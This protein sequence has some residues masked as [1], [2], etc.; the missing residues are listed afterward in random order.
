MSRHVNQELGNRGFVIAS[1]FLIVVTL[2]QPWTAVITVV[3]GFFVL[4]A[5]LK[6]DARGF[7]STIWR[8]LLI[9]AFLLGITCLW[10]WTTGPGSY[11]ENWLTVGIICT[12][13]GGCGL[14]H[15]FWL[16]PYLQRREERKGLL[17]REQLNELYLAEGFIPKHH[18]DG[19]MTLVR[20]SQN[21]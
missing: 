20:Q 8:M 13:L 7:F 14:L 12:V 11:R 15:S 10:A 1:I 3:F 19:T 4:V 18:P 17:T 21:N 5:W 2:L 9:A 16:K 6:T